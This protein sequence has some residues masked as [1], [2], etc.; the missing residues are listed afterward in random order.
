M[1]QQLLHRADIIASLKQMRREAMT[2]GVAAPW[3]GDFCR[4]HSPFDGILQRL[5][6]DV[7]PAFC[8][9]AWVNR[10]S[11]SG[12]DILPAP[13]TACRGVFSFKRKRQIDHAE[14]FREVLLVQDLHLLQLPFQGLCKGLRQHRHAIF[15]ALPIADEGL[16]IFQVDILDAQSDAFHQVQARAVEQARHQP[17][18]A[19]DMRQHCPD[20]G[21]GEDHR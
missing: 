14:A 19:V 3:L 21:R 10:A 17:V 7:M 20:L 15:L 5:F 1:P 6:V 2:K 9:G 18:L 12:K 13:R 16:T 8:A 11:A 4:A